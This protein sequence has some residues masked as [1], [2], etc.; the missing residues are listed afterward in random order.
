MCG[1]AGQ[2]RWTGPTSSA[3][4]ARM[5]AVLRHRGPDA[6]GV[7]TFGEACLGHRRLSVLD[8]SAAAHQPM[9][10]CTGRFAIV[11]NGEI[12][13]F[14]EL[15]RDLEAAGASFRSS[16]DT[17]VLLEAYKAWGVDCIRRLN[18][19]FAFALWDR[20]ERRLLLARDRLGKK[21][22]FW[23]S[24]PDGGLSFA[25]EIKALGQDP[26]LARTT[27]PRAIGHLLS[28]GYILGSESIWTGV[29]KLPPAHWMVIDPSGQVRQQ[30][31]WDLAAAYADKRK[32]SEGEAAEAVLA[33]LD[34]A[35]RLRLMADVPVGAFLSGGIDSAAIVTSMCHLG[36][37][38]AVRTFSTGFDEPGFDERA[39]ARALASW[40][41]V[42]HRDRAIQADIGTLLPKIAWHA[43][44]P[45]A[46][47]SMLPMYALAE[48]A[49]DDVVVALSGD[50]GDE[51]FGG[52]ETYVADLLRH[53]TRWLPRP[54]IILA[55]RWLDSVPASWSKVGFQF[56]LKQFLAAHGRDPVAAHFGWRE[57]FRHE[58]KH[59]LLR[60][61]HRDDVMAADPAA[62]FRHFDRDVSGLS[63]LD[64]MSYIDI[65]TWLV[66]DILVK[67]DRATMAHGLEARAPFLDYRLV[68]LAASLPPDF[69]L[70]RLTKKWILKKA[71][72]G[73]VPQA[74]L[75]R[76]KKGFNAPLA[77]WLDPAKGVLAALT[78][79][80][81]AGAWFRPEAVT[82][83][84]RD[85][86][87]RRAD[88]SHKLMALAALA[89]WTRNQ[90]DSSA[91]IAK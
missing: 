3:V 7:A 16:G 42:D 27:N 32:L 63:L 40:L 61:E 21:P 19:M 83:L 12:Y 72:A 52:Y 13:N 23:A 88:N 8:V 82:G 75:A 62:E 89:L 24:T 34:D 70:R 1:I 85:H 67:V 64:R 50:G 44:E 57:I 81:L 29:R 77:H 35:V 51:I 6:E 28:L 90:L 41:G 86:H 43:D 30:C 87:D 39:E 53:R 66:D 56:K 59:A 11:Y 47:T 45:F 26:G 15:R 37:S 22:L 17:E 91:T 33:L 80:E 25:S 48:M 20:E 69:K 46:D 5:V 4:V 60:P 2:V 68:E 14:R 55:R 31:Y 58:E 9:L 79:D 76:P 65:K 49:R 36:P 74:V 10:D 84:I 78:V 73:R 54:L 18:G 71:L 38:A